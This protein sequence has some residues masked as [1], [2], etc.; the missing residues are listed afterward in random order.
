MSVW[1]G[2]PSSAARV[3]I[4]IKSG[5]DNLTLTLRFLMN[6]ARAAFFKALEFGF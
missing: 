2:T 5:E 6:V 3:W 1:Y 4:S